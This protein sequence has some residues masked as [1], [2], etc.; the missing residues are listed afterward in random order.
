MGYSMRYGEYRFTRWQKYENPKEVVAVELY[1]HG[2]GPLAIKN[3]A[4]SPAYEDRVREM[5][6]LLSSELS[7]Y[8][9]QRPGKE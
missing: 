2:N 6:A 5:D 4:D 7:K 1:G 8:K 9:L 3:L